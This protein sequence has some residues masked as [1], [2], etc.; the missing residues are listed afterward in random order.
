MTISFPPLSP[1]NYR[2][3]SL[4]NHT[5]L[6]FQATPGGGSRDTN[7]VNP[8]I[9]RAKSAGKAKKGTDQNS[10]KIGGNRELLMIW[11]MEQFAFF[12]TQNLRPGVGK[13]QALGLHDIL[14]CWM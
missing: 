13:L 2:S 9:L 14:A 11:L 6:R 10:S 1:T 8:P 12:R 5:K 7:T 3:R 4:K